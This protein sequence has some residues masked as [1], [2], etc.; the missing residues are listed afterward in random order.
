MSLKPSFKGQTRFWGYSLKDVEHEDE[1][2]EITIDSS[3]PIQDDS[4]GTYDRSPL[5]A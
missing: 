2:G 4:A 1:L 5:E 3:I